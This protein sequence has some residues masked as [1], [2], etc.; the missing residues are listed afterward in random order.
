MQRTVQVESLQVHV[1]AHKTASTHLQ[2]ILGQNA[3]HLLAR[4]VGFCGPA[5]LRDD[6]VSQLDKS[7]RFFAG[8]AGRPGLRSVTNA[9]VPDCQQ[10]VLSEENIAGIPLTLGQGR[11]L[12][13]GLPKKLNTLRDLFP[14]AAMRCFMSTRSYADFYRSVYCELVRNRGWQPFEKHIHYELVAQHSWARLVD[15]I[16]KKVPGLE[17]VIWPY[18]QYDSLLNT[19]LDALLGAERAALLNRRLFSTRVRPSLSAAALKALQAMEDDGRNPMECSAEM[20]VLYPVSD[21]FPAYDPWTEEQRAVLDD[22]YARDLQEIAG[23]PGV[24]LLG[25]ANEQR[26]A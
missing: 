3:D 8:R 2:A 6:W 10:L 15:G 23:M 13:Q 25:H 1:G 19:I 24:S 9:L 17:L 11:R 18:E 4:G 14:S 22:N 16:R 7:S 20:L 5:V 26:D 21:E 12:Y